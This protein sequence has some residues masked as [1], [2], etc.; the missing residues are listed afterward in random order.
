[1]L[2]DIAQK[3][4]L[5]VLQ[6]SHAQEAWAMDVHPS[7]ALVATGAKSG[8]IRLWNTAENRPVVGKVRHPL[9]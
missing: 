2:V 4:T 6:V 7:L 9:L 5:G 8:A 3:A 1:M